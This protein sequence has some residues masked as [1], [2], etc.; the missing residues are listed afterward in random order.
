MMWNIVYIF[1]IRN[2]VMFLITWVLRSFFMDSTVN[3]CKRIR[4]KWLDDFYFRDGAL[5]RV[6][7]STLD[8]L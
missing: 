5:D 1:N 8:T 2:G 4:E 3:I 6:Y 7:S